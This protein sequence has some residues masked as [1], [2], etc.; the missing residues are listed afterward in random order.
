MPVTL[1]IAPD[2]PRALQ[3]IAAG[4]TGADLLVTT[5]GASVGEHDLVREALGETG[6]VLDFWQIAMRPGKPLMVGTFRGTPMIGLP[7]N[8]VST[9]VCS[10]PVP[11]AGDRSSCSGLAP[12]RCRLAERAAAS[13]LSAN[14][15]RQDYLRATLTRAL[16]RHARGEAVRQAGFAR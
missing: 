14:D 4:A 6:L 2:D 9:M 12:T 13:A 11:E 10:L 16:R 7:G 5:G 3:R 15:R 8:P 1:P